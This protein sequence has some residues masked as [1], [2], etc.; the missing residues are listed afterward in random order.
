MGEILPVSPA[1]EKCRGYPDKHHQ[2]DEVRQYRL[3][4]HEQRW[5]RERDKYE[6]NEQSPNSFHSMSFQLDRRSMLF[7]CVR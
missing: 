6:D 7:S 4:R 2:H 5:Y 3:Y 1:V